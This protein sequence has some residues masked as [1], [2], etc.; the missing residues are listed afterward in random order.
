MRRLIAPTLAALAAAAITAG[1]ALAGHSHRSVD[2][3]PGHEEHHS[4]AIGLWGD[5]PYS[6]TQATVGVPN[7]IADM[8]SQDLAFSAHDGDIK[9]GSSEC[10]DAVYTQAL[11][12]FNSLR[13]PAVFTPGDNDW[14]DCDRT[15]GYNDRVQL[16]KERKLYFATP[17]TLGQH[18]LR[19]EVQQTPLCLGASG[20]TPC[21]ENRRWTLGGVTYGT[22]NIQG[23]CNNLCDSK[24]GLGDADPAE[25]AARNAAD[26]AWMKETFA[27]AA[28]RRS[29]AVMFISQADPGF[30]DDAV[31]GAPTRNPQTL[32]E[33]DA[34]SSTDGFGD[35]LR[36]LRDQTVAFRKP[37]VYV[38]GDSHYFRIDKPLENAQGQRVENFTRLETF[39]DHQENGNN[40]VNW[41][42]VTV[43]PR[44]REVFSFQPE[45]VPANRTAVP[46]P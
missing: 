28:A 2:F 46:S 23:T 16:D 11:S 35:F 6:T 45:I 19:Q 37:V 41:V 7:L 34:Q 24:A 30:N 8:N 39:G 3:G 1:I 21:V 20:T 22:L 10:T 38:H 29:A 17:F 42:K 26:I 43:D 14:V 40:D 12:Y 31:Q 5:L 27:E 15:P 13:A 44:S 4:Y 33:D 32:A 18:R 9:A 36:A 25:Y